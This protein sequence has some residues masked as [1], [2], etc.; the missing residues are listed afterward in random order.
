[1]MMMMLLLGIKTV[2]TKNNDINSLTTWLLQC[3]CLLTTLLVEGNVLPT[4]H[5]ARS[6]I[7]TTA[8]YMY[9]VFVACQGG[10]TAGGC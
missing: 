9:A 10:T 3:E 6:F 8:S 2:S 7:T 4:D 5:S 1:M